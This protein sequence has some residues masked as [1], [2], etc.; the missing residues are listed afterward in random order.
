MLKRRQFDLLTAKHKNNLLDAYEQ[1]R[2][3]D[4]TLQQ[5]FLFKRNNHIEIENF[6]SYDD[7]KTRVILEILRLLKILGFPFIELQNYVN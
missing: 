3:N 2:S 5:Y 6:S 4:N 7:Q 1:L